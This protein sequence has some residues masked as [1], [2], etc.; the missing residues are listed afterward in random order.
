M[1]KFEDFVS[2]DY[3]VVGYKGQYP[4][5]SISSSVPTTGYTME[6]V[7]WQM[8]ET[9]NSL[10]DEAHTYHN[11]DDENH[12][13]ESYMK[14][15]LTELHH[16]INEAYHNKMGSKLPLVNDVFDPRFQGS[17]VAED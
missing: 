1:K 6:P 5:Y 8:N 11:D 16:R 3:T 15:A 9:A 14:E 7:V 10:A 13:G 4:N 2:E 12:T 17:D